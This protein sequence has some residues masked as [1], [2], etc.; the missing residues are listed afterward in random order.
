MVR[1]AALLSG[2]GAALLLA[3]CGGAAKD[4]SRAKIDDPAVIDALA[5]PIMTDP[6]LASQNDAHAAISVT[7]AVSAALPPIE[8]DDD[9]IDAA[10]DEAARLVG[11]MP[12]AAPDPAAANLEPF[13]ESVTAAQMAVAARVPGSDC[14]AR[15]SYTARWATALPEP[16]SV[17]PRGAVDEAA[18]SDA[19]CR[20]RVVHFRTPV[21]VDDVLGFYHARLR[22]A[23]FAVQ[24][25]ADGADHLLRGNKGGTGYV[26]YLRA[27]EDGLTMADVV[28]GG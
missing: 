14:A 19:G 5:D 15:V 22:A 12:A 21:A 11:G 7:G 1:I 16:L 8:A 10:K 25:Q 28:A 27:G 13:R 4:A 23:G 20:L 26:V 17:Y 2:A 9:A 18:G 6:E 3:G 24:H